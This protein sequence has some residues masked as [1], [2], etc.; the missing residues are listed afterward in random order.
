VTLTIDACVW[1]AALSV[2]EADHAA[3]T[4]LLHTVVADGHPLHQPTL[5]VI[6]VCATI[7]RTTRDPVLATSVVE[8]ILGTPALRLH[9]LDHDRTAEAAH[10]AMACA[11]RG[12]DAVYAATARAAGATLV[13]LDREVLERAAPF[14]PATSPRAWLDGRAAP[15]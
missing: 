9:P 3:C 7:A 11:L 6:E 10:A 13:T 2:T 4:E 15:R 14:V 8:A 1:L 12:A 5:F